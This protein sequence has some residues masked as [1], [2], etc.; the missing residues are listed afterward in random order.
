MFNLMRYLRI[1]MGTGDAS[2]RRSTRR[3]ARILSV[4]RN[5]GRAQGLDRHGNHKA[6]YELTPMLIVIVTKRIPEIN[7]NGLD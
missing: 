6:P 4:C 2:T 3:A 5:R 7:R 1:I